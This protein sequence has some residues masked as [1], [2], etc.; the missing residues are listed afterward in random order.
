MVSV[1]LLSSLPSLL[2]AALKGCSVI[3]DT[4][5]GRRARLLHNASICGSSAGFAC[6][7]TAKRVSI[8]ALY[9]KGSPCSLNNSKDDVC[10]TPHCRTW[11]M[12][13][14]AWSPRGTTLITSPLGLQYW[15]LAKSYLSKAETQQKKMEREVKKQR[16]QPRPFYFA[17]LSIQADA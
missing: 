1:H 16:L 5:T 9:L 7:R 4:S 11:L 3:R 14:S 13:S 10:V 17:Q 8:L 15:E 2:T 12:R 6:L